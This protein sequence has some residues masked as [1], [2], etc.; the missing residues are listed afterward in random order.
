M[1]PSDRL[2]IRPVVNK[3]SRDVTKASRLCCKTVT[4]VSVGFDR[5]RLAVVTSFAEGHDAV[6]FCKNG[7]VLSDSDIGT[8]MELGA[9]LANDDVAGAN[10]FASEALDAQ[11][12]R[13]RVA[14][15][16]G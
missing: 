9:A 14:T 16:L 12:F 7:I 11:S 8:G 3:K 6:C 1:K 2:Y 10:H 4:A 15:V 13:F 5:N